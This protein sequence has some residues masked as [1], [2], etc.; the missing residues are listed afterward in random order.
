MDADVD[1]DLRSEFITDW[2]EVDF[3]TAH[4]GDSCCLIHLVLVIGTVIKHANCR[5]F[6]K[7]VHEGSA[8]SAH[9]RCG[10][11]K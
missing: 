7:E 10:T 1:G 9:W 2:G 4:L 3:P 8:L 5:A 11:V 6:P